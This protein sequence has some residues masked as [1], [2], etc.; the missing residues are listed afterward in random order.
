MKTVNCPKHGEQW[1]GL[2]CKHVAFALI[3]RERVGFYWGDDT[4]TARP[5][6][7]CSECEKVLVALN[8]AS[9]EDWF[10]KGEFKVLCAT[11]WDEAKAVCHQ[12]RCM[13]EAVPKHFLSSNYLLSEGREF[14]T[15]LRL[16]GWRYYRGNF[17]IAGVRYEL[18][19][20][21]FF[22]GDFTIFAERRVL[23]RA[24]KPSI[25]HN[26]FQLQLFGR[27]FVLYQHLGGRPT[28]ILFESNREMGRVFQ[29]SVFTRRAC[30]ELPDEW[31]IPIRVFIFW[32]ALVTWNWQAG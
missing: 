2:V 15:E 19:R 24:T 14:V 22:R 21:R 23:A 6:A 27:N 5:D 25:F 1:I 17:E 12:K 13:I 10:Q 4:D 9:S 3:R 18:G 32:L 20:E 16:S 28:F 11:C 29:R 8:G 26:C 7:W 31:P 30:I